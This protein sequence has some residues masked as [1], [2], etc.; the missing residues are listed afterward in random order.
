MSAERRHATVCVGNKHNETVAT[1]LFILNTCAVCCNNNMHHDTMLNLWNVTDCVNRTVL[2]RCIHSYVSA[3]VM[4]IR[5][6]L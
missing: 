4:V 1:S 5:S 3:A 2:D 6:R